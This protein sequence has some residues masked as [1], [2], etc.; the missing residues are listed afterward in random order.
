[1]REIN[2]SSYF[3]NEKIKKKKKKVFNWK[4]QEDCR[5]QS[6]SCIFEIF[7]LL[8]K[9]DC[10]FSDTN[11]INMYQQEKKSKNSIEDRMLNEFLYKM[12]LN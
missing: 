9:V 10:N 8:V 6:I 4:N 5:I 3:N 12:C 11:I 1:M 7:R 2:N